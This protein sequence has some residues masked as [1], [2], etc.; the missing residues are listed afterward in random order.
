MILGGAHGQAP[1]RRRGRGTASAHPYPGVRAQMRWSRRGD[2]AVR[3]CCA[4]RDRF[5]ADVPR[6]AYF[7]ADAA[8]ATAGISALSA[9]PVRLRGM[10]A[11][12]ADCSLQAP[13][14][15]PLR[16]GQD[17]EKNGHCAA[18]DGNV[19]PQRRAPPLPAATSRLSHAAGAEK[20]GK[21]DVQ[22]GIR[23]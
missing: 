15:P 23:D 18:S 11:A 7:F 14:T 6:P 19:E 1:L 13:T 17:G 10:H 2:V 20:S 3:S 4:V 22:S 16:N 12:Q 21:G 8:A 9:V 5:G